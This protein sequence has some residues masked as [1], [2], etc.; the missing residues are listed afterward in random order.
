MLLKVHLLMH[1]KG[2]KLAKIPGKRHLEYVP[3]SI[4]SVHSLSY[5]GETGNH[6]AEPQNNQN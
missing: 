5:F 3:I 1:A 2:F 4:I 6:A